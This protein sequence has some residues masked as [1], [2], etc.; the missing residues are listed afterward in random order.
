MLL[1]SQPIRTAST[2]GLL[3]PTSSQVL[4]AVVEDHANLPTGKLHRPPRFSVDWNHP[5]R[6]K[7]SCGSPNAPALMHWFRTARRYLGLTVYPG[8]HVSAKTRA[9]TLAAMDSLRVTTRFSLP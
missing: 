9:Q 7:G 3:A 5:V 1:S 4:I 2:G 6:L 8:S